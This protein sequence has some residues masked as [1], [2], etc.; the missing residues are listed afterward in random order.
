[1]G[2][3]TNRH[4]GAAAPI[5]FYTS[6]ETCAGLRVVKYTQYSNCNINVTE[7]LY[8]ELAPYWLYLYTGET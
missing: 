6:I 8:V 7:F 4:S 5:G 3:K 2:Q 1:M